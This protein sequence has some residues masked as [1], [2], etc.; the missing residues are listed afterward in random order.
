MDCIEYQIEDGMALF[1]HPTTMAMLLL[2]YITM[3]DNNNSF[4]LTKWSWM[5]SSGHEDIMTT[6]TSAQT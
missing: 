5:N 3:S 4:G 2:T 6:M 1:G